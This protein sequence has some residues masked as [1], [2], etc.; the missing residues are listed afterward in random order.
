MRIAGVVFGVAIFVSGLGATAQGQRTVAIDSI[1]LN[2]SIQ[3]LRD[4]RGKWTVET[5]FLNADGS[6]ARRVVGTYRFDWALDD[7]ILVGVSEIPELRTA[8]GILFYIAPARSVIEMVSVGTDGMLWTMTGAL[9][10]E[11]RT[12]QPFKTQQGSESR[13]R[14]TRYNV[15]TDRFESRMEHTEDGGKSWLPGN[16]QVFRRIAADPRTG[17]LS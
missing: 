2:H 4:T 10:G 3:Q 6:I 9:G 16:H 1:A 11:T 8:S 7:K 5:E 17:D 15:T 12:T 13:L 14:F